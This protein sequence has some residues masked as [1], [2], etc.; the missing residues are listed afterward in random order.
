MKKLLL[1]LSFALIT[2]ICFS[3]TILYDFDNAT[4]SS[5]L[6]EISQNAIVNGVNYQVKIEHDAPGGADLHTLG[7]NDKFIKGTT[8]ARSEQNWTVRIVSTGQNVNFN[9][10][11]VE[12]QHFGGGTHTFIIGDTNNNPISAQATIQPGGS[13]TFVVDPAN[14]A[15]ATDINEFLIFGFSFS[16]TLEVYFNNLRLTPTALLSNDDFNKEQVNY[17]QNSSMNLVLSHSS[18]E[19]T[20]IQLFNTAGQLMK[21]I[22]PQANRIEIDTQDFASGLYIARVQLDDSVQSIKFME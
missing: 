4:V 19:A 15:F 9:F 2:T 3:Q 12:Y 10:E 5:N 6:T 14:V 13:G 16:A 7:A 21:T 8:G 17:F 1:S 20:T 18:L 11:S 22:S